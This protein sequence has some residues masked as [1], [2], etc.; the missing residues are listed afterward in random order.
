MQD[1]SF[2]PFRINTQVRVEMKTKQNEHANVKTR[3]TMHA[4]R[5][6]WLNTQYSFISFL[7]F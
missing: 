2:K 3:T 1:F 7:R 4:T 5:H 6:Y